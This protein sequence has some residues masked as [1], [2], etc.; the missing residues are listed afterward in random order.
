MYNFNYQAP[1][2][3]GAAVAALKA[4]E[5]GKLMAGG[6]TLIPTLKQRLAR[7]SDV[8]DL[9]KIGTL[10][11]IRRDGNA[12]VIGAMTSHAEVA[13]SELVRSTIPALADLADG[14]GDPQV[15]NRG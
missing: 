11:G 9:G 6:Q 4:S 14:I 15:R 13:A 1:T 8:I 12:I 5:D 2:D 10:K 7:P 3:V